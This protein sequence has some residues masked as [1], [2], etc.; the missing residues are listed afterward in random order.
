M[1][2]PNTLINLLFA[3]PDD[4]Y[5]IEGLI[6]FADLNQY[7][8][9]LLHKNKVCDVV[10][11]L[12]SDGSE[13]RVKGF[14]REE[15]FVPFSHNIWKLR[16]F[17][18]SLQNWIMNRLKDKDLRC[19]I[20]CSLSSFCSLY[21]SERKEGDKKTEIDK[22]LAELIRLS[23]NH[24]QRKGFFL[25]TSSPYIEESKELLFHSEIFTKHMVDD[26]YQ[27]LSDA[28]EHAGSAPSNHVYE[29]L[30][31]GLNTACVFLNRFEEDQLR[32]LIHHVLLCENV[33]V[34]SKLSEK[35]PGHL[36]KLLNSEIFYTRQ[37]LA[38]FFDSEIPNFN[39]LY[40]KLRNP[41]NW[42]KL[43]EIYGLVYGNQGKGNSVISF[44]GQERSLLPIYHGDVAIKGCL[45]L[46][47]SPL[48]EHDTELKKKFLRMKQM[49][50]RVKNQKIN[51]AIKKEMSNAASFYRDLLH[52]GENID[53]QKQLIAFMEC[54]A[55][56]LY[57]TAGGQKEHEIVE[58]AK[59]DILNNAT[60]TRE[61]DEIMA[62]VENLDGS[63]LQ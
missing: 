50:L 15:G 27:C 59:N 58:L 4:T 37:I 5:Y 18:A 61:I 16:A 40:A 30:R 62:G 14:G 48:L 8:W 29:T 47:L 46:L 6:Q 44:E 25:L 52:D 60:S 51:D 49:L 32:A 45:T 56:F 7:I 1:F 38:T 53:G 10:Y 17:K 21:R 63:W 36:A 24:S 12:D 39:K 57:E 22:P 26:R 19:T 28:I 31:N 11:F 2:S 23:N 33:S 9:Y 13:F 20:V 41:A 42:S 55:T 35:L 34:D 43:E 3:N 54:C